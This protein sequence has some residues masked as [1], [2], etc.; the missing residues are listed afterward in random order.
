[1]KLIFSTLLIFT[2]A[3]VLFGQD[4]NPKPNKWRGMI[5][6]ESTADDVL[7]TFGAPE[8]DE[9]SKL[10]FIQP[11]WISKQA[12]DN[13]YRKLEFKKVE[14]FNKVQ[15]YFD[16]KN[17]L[18]IID[19]DPD[20]K[21]NIPPENLTKAYGLEFAPIFA[22]LDEAFNPQDFKR[23][24]GKAY[25]RSYPTYYRLGG[26]DERVFVLAGIDNSSFGAILGKSMGVPNQAN[27]LPGKVTTIQLISR[28]L[29]N[30]DGINTLK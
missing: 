24:Q 28:S 6:D 13:K 10:Y 12:K 23:E 5:I 17:I 20:K 2:F 16:S 21:N 1:M 11:K 25:A 14:N 22:A 8:K 18:K 29:E 3:F 7:K 9:Q 30:K 19:L 15:F 4:D 26:A 27:S